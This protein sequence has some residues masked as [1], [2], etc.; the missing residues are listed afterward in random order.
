MEEMKTQDTP[1]KKGP[2]KVAK[3]PI[4]GVKLAEEKAVML[5]PTARKPEQLNQMA[6]EQMVPEP[7]AAEQKAA[8]TKTVEQKR[9]QQEKLLRHK[10]FLE[11]HEAH[12]LQSA[13]QKPV[14]TNAVK[15]PPTRN[16][17]SFQFPK[18][19]A[20]DNSKPKLSSTFQPVSWTIAKTTTLARAPVAAPS[21]V[22]PV[23]LPELI[24]ISM[25][26][27]PTTAAALESAIEQQTP[28]TSTFKLTE[29]I[30]KVA[31]STSMLADTRP[32]MTQFSKDVPTEPKFKPAIARPTPYRPFRKSRCEFLTGNPY[33]MEEDEDER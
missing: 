27:T 6:P 1:T 30:S 24:E 29:P 18:P 12:Q 8:A 31:K 3:R 7:K 32:T 10:R 33:E 25:K 5:K 23:S 11:Q 20:S 17:I 16:S 26:M 9:A 22:K 14:L 28:T 15:E 13:E 19:P 21:P 4:P 2:Q